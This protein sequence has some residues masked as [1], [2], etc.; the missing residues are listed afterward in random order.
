MTAIPEVRFHVVRCDNSAKVLL[1][2]PDGK[3]YLAPVKQIVP[4]DT[5]EWVMIVSAD[6]TEVA[7]NEFV[8]YEACATRVKALPDLPKPHAETVVIEARDLNI[9]FED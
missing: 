4:Y 3:I 7:M 5:N 1:L 6:Q 2:A 9:K 8:N